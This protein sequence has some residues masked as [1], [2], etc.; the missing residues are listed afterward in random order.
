M[1]LFF[2][3]FSIRCFIS[4]I[5][6]V[7]WSRN[8]RGNCFQVHNIVLYPE[9]HSW[10]Q[11]TAIKQIVASPGYEPTTI[12]NNVCVGACFSYSI[13]RTQPAEPGELIGPYCDSCQPAETKC[14]HVSSMEPVWKCQG[15]EWVCVLL[16]VFAFSCSVRWSSTRITKTT[17][18]R[19]Q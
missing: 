14:Y 16:I 9:R 17:M 18:V 6:K 4:K 5:R 10:C 13:P 1:K 8:K 19:K 2:V 12:D 15:S 7:L 3:E 11:T